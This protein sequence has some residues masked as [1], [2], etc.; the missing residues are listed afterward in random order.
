MSNKELVTDLLSRL[1]ENVSLHDIATE[2]QFIAGVR[3][4]L[5]QLDRGEGEPIE[6]VEKM[7]AT[8]T[9]R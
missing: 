2:I 6:A 4:G 5:A 8:W 1:P 3:E 9:T 7:I